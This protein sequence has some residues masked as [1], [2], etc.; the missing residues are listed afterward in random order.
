MNDVIL[1]AEVKPGMIGTNQSAV[2]LAVWNRTAMR[3]LPFVLLYTHVKIIVEG[4]ARNMYQKPRG[5]KIGQ[6]P[7]W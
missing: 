1:L 4:I 3:R 5:A 2:L 7:G 6:V